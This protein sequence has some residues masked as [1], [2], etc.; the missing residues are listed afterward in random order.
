[1]PM[2]GHRARIGYTSPPSATEVF[3]YEFYKIVPDGVTLVVHTL[4]LVDRT[5][6]EVDRSYHASLK[7]AK[8]MARAGVDILVFGGLPIN[9]SRGFDNLDALISETEQEVGIPISTSA[10]SQRDAFAALGSNKVGIVQPYDESHDERHMGYMREFGLDPQGC[11]RVGTKFI[12]LGKVPDEVAPALG[13]EIMD[14]FPDVDTIYYS[15]PHWAMVGAI[16]TLEKEFGVTVVQPI[17]AIIWQA[18]RRSGVDDAIEGYGRL[19]RD[20]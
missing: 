7:A 13:R 9:V 20:F 3:P 16:D 4:P 19:L 17:Q 2:Y 10:T 6:E 15:C 8:I 18:L 11:A 12:D 1:M 5:E 14:K